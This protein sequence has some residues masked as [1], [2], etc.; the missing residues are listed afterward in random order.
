MQQLNLAKTSIEVG[1]NSLFAG[2]RSLAVRVNKFL[3]ADKQARIAAAA[4]AQVK[5]RASFKRV[6]PPAPAR[7]GRSHQTPL[8]DAIRWVATPD[9]SVALDVK[10]LDTEVPFWLIQE[11]GTGGEGVMK[12]TDPVTGRPREIVRTIRSQKGRPIPTSLVWASSPTGGYTPGGQAT[13]QQLFLR[14]KVRGAPVAA[15]NGRAHMRIS[16]EIRGQHFIQ[17]GSDTGFRQY[18]TDVLAAARRTFMKSGSL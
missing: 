15:S 13:G 9:G 10:K 14:S 6:R 1:K 16:R 3:E 17:K 2:S 18:E 4:A 8:V 7:P 12:A 5:S 11:V